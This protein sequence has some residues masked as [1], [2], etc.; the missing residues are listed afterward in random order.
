MVCPSG[1]THLFQN[2]KSIR[3]SD[4]IV[5]QIQAQIVEGRLAEGQKKPNDQDIAKQFGVSRPSYRKA[6]SMQE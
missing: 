1:G 6:I 4:Q 3:V 5:S 2:I